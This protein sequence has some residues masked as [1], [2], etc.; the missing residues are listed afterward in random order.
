MPYNIIVCVKQVPDTTDVKIDPVTKT[1]V[2]EGVPAIVNPFDTYALEEAIRIRERLGGKV[3]ALSMGPP[4]AADALRECLAIGADEAVLLSDRAFAGSDTLA[5]AYALSLAIKRLG[6]DIV[7]CGKQAW[8][9]DTGQVGPGIAEELN[10]PHVT[11]VR[12]LVLDGSCAVVERLVEG[13]YERVRTSL[14]ALFTVV[15]EI[16]EPRLPSLRGKIKAK[17]A[18]IPVWGPEDIGADTSRLGLLGSPTEVVRVFSPELRTRG[19]VKELSG[20]DAARYLLSKLEGV[21]R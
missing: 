14:P 15:K 6:A 4:Q 19:E 13:G 20:P 18:K 10:I 1:L 3:T 8:D 9:G 7:L 21:I 11:Y 16:N 2:R 5:T 17:S 12:K